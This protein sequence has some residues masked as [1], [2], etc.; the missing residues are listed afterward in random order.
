MADANIQYRYLVIEGT[1]YEVLSL[2]DSLG[3]VI[4]TSARH[5]TAA[6][7]RQALVKLE[8]VFNMRIYYGDTRRDCE[9]FILDRFR[10]FYL[11]K[12]KGEL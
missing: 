6:S 7:I 8:L 9:R 4:N 3:G 2:P 5:L 10:K 11:Y 12:R 1:E